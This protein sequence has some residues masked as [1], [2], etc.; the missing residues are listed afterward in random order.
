[1]LFGALA[2]SADP[3]R[4]RLWQTYERELVRLEATGD[5]EARRQL[6]LRGAADPQAGAE[7]RCRFHLEAARA[8]QQLERPTEALDELAAAG[9]EPASE[10]CTERA[11]LALARSAGTP[12]AARAF[13]VNHP[14][15]TA[16]AAVLADV[17]RGLDDA[18]AAAQISD[19]AG[20][21]DDPAARCVLHLEL[22]KRLSIEQPEHALA[23]AD[24]VATASCA[25][26]PDAALTAVHLL[27]DLQRWPDVQA[28]FDAAA[29]DTLAWAACRALERAPD[30]DAR[31][32]ACLASFATRFPSSRKCDDA[33]FF[34]AERAEHVGDAPAALDLYRRIVDERPDSGRAAQAGRRLQELRAPTRP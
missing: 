20:H 5:H 8:L 29:D 32:A 16:Y 14:R 30:G 10:A 22:A 33:W 26:S 21:T 15:S 2:C 6:A 9:R 3:V 28:R 25:R 7:E 17:L 18:A 34:L 31:S 12:V 24:E 1:M 19:L 11:D 4:A 23:L 13:L 27:A